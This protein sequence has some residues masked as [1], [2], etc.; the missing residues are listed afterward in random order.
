MT[1]QPSA[2]MPSPCIGVCRM[3]ERSGLCLGC[4]RS[5]EEI[6]VWRQL[7]EAE[8]RRIWAGLP[9]RFE[10]LGLKLA[11]LPWTEA[12]MRDF[13]REKLQRREGSWAVGC[14]GA[15]A[16]FRVA[17]GEACD[18]DVAEGGVTARSAQG[19]LRL[20][21][22][23]AVRV[24]A[25][26]ETPGASEPLALVFALARQRAALPVAGGLA[27]LGPDRRAIEPPERQQ[28]LYDLGIG[29]GTMRF[30]IRTGNP[31]LM[32]VLNAA[33]GLPWPDYLPAVGGAILKESPVRVVESALARAEI[34]TP[35]P[36]PGTSSIAGPHTHLLPELLALGHEVAP[37]VD[38]P[39]AFAAGAIFYPEPPAD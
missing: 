16:E 18:L 9:T 30:C 17:P 3:D 35:I 23:P 13:V 1:L 2:L 28:P 15:V 4:A 20:G 5:G 6:A 29:R 21:I 8:R 36:P 26:Y 11:R 38:L 22:G 25:L 12:E 33:K 10:R 27:S 37:G 34:R 32:A 31:A 14:Y 39:A 7:G 24:L 19:A